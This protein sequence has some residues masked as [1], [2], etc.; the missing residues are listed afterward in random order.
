VTDTTNSSDVPEDLT[1]DSSD[2]DDEPDGAL[3]RGGE[4]VDEDDLEDD[5]DESDDDSEDDEDSDESDDDDD[6]DEDDEEAARRDPTDADLF[7][8]S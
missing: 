8:Q 4:A 7:R 3:N 2:A 6:E 1:L 5:S